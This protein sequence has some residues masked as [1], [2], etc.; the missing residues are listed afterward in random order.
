MLMC[1]FSCILPNM[2]F[3]ANLIIFMH[4]TLLHLFYLTLSMLFSNILLNKMELKE[5]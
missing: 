1:I 5:Y 4:V 3:F 2:L